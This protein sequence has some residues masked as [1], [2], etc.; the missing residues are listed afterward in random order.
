MDLTTQTRDG[1][2]LEIV[3]KVDKRRTDLPQEAEYLRRIV[4]VRGRQNDV[5]F[6]GIGQK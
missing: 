6:F 3:L 4:G 1:P 2:Y 5:F